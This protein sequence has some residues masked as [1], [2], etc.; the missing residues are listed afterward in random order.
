MSN[1]T[2]RSLLG[3]EGVGRLEGRL[4]RQQIT[5]DINFTCDGVITKWIIGA[6][7]ANN[8]SLVPGPELQLWRNT[9]NDTYVKINGTLVTSDTYSSSLIYENSI[10]PIPFQAGDVLGIFLPRAAESSLR[11]RSEVGYGPLN[12]FITTEEDA[13]MSQ[14]DELQLSDLSSDT[15]HPLVSLE[16]CELKSCTLSFLYFLLLT[17]QST[18]SSETKNS[19]QC[20]TATPTNKELISPTRIIATIPLSGTGSTTTVLV[21]SRVTSTSPSV[22]T[23]TSKTRETS[24]TGSTKNTGSLSGGVIGVGVAVVV[25]IVGALILISVTVCL[26]QRKKKKE[27]LITASNVVYHSASGQLSMTKDTSANEYEYVSIHSPHS[28]H[29]P[30]ISGGGVVISSNKAYGVTLREDM[31][32]NVAYGVGQNEVEVKDNEAYTTTATGGG[33]GVGEEYDYI[34]RT[35]NITI[36]A[37]PNEAHGTTMSGDAYELLQS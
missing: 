9:G 21:S 11:L 12:Y 15:Y 25:L 1:E 27:L 29:T 18:A 31:T 14:Y 32:E 13:H 23:D 34:V 3:L 24:S 5:P 16:I 4:R 8:T 36:T 28:D 17:A 10:S 20:T 6:L 2:L 26:R 7:R 35:D 37:M 19:K 33:A 22:M 30:N